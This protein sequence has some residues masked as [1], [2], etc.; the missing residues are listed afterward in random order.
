MIVTTYWA[1]QQWSVEEGCWSL[2]LK[3]DHDISVDLCWFGDCTSFLPPKAGWLRLVCSLFG[4]IFSLKMWEHQILFQEL[5]TL[6]V[7]VANYQRTVDINVW[8][9]NK[10]PL[11]T[12]V[13]SG[14]CQPD[15]QI[16]SPA[17]YV[18]NQDFL[19]CSWKKNKYSQLRFGGEAVEV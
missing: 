18:F 9:L 7:I 1:F 15:V 5:F 14:S 2:Y 10:W 19:K 16:L 8:I 13:L 4:I 11:R 17:R 6:S 3:M 12:E